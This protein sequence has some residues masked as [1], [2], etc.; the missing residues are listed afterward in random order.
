MSR[1]PTKEEPRVKR[2]RTL[3]NQFPTLELTGRVL[4]RH[5]DEESELARGD[6]RFYV[7]DSLSGPPLKQG[8]YES[9]GRAGYLKAEVHDGKE[10]RFL[11]MEDF[12]SDRL[13]HFVKRERP[14]D[15]YANCRE[16]MEDMKGRMLQRIYREH[17]ELA[18]EV[19]GE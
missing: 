14:I 16:R 12:F 10:W 1:K 17:Y 3:G 11:V 8:D 5:R 7:H 19:E 4:L 13:H 15:T 9:T 2:Y 6:V 18:P